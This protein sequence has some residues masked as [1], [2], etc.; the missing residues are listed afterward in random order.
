MA[1]KVVEPVFVDTNNLV[2]ANDED[3]AFHADARARLTELDSSGCDLRINRQVLREYAVVVGRKMHEKNAFDA[4]ALTADLSRFETEFL[5]ADEDQEVTAQ[6]KKLI[7][8]HAVKG[9][10]VHD[11]NIVATM[12]THGITRLLTQ[13]EGD[14]TRYRPLIEVLS[15]V[16]ETSENPAP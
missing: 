9:K 14:F 8:S 15:L 12:L 11:A 5:V 6:L 7:N 3:S 16:T 1:T 4:K 10:P 2:H 13:N